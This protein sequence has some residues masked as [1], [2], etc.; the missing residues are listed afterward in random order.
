MS[1]MFDVRSCRLSSAR[2][3]I[4]LFSNWRGH[5]IYSRHLCEHIY[6][7]KT[8]MQCMCW[9]WCEANS[10]R[11]DTNRTRQITNQ[12]PLES[13]MNNKPCRRTSHITIYHCPAPLRP[14]EP[15]NIYDLS[16][17]HSARLPNTTPHTA[18][19]TRRPHRKTLGYITWVSARTC[20]TWEAQYAFPPSAITTDA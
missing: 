20:G 16:H 18:P 10:I 17:T 8:W 4:K 6:F 7:E 3:H 11:A 12:F 1:T 5:L 9:W 19:N 15:L 2:N 13:F 14:Q